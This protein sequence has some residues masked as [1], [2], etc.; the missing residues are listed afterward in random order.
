MSESTITA[1]PSSTRARGPFRAVV[2]WVG[3]VAAGLLALIVIAIAAVYGITGRR[4]AAHFTVPEHN[5]VVASDSAT[6]A[7]GE[8]IA[9]IRGCVECHGAGLRGATAVRSSSCRRASS[10]F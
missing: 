7:R 9:T 1:Q 4:F 5:I 10:T 8:H 2:R 6:I 3:R